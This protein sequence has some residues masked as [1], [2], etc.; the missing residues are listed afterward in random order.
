MNDKGEHR[1]ARA[2]KN[3]NTFYRHYGHSHKRASCLTEHSQRAFAKFKARGGRWSKPKRMET[4]LQ[5][6]INIMSFRKL[7]QFLHRINP[8]AEHM[9]IAPVWIRHQI[10]QVPKET[11]AHHTEFSQKAHLAFFQSP[12]VLSFHGKDKNIYL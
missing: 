8:P 2:G 4:R 5:V 11:D 1:A 3:Y 10:S 12:L 7:S 9:M 6:N